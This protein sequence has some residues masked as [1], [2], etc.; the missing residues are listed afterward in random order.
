MPVEDPVSLITTDTLIEPSDSLSSAVS[1]FD[2]PWRAR[3]VIA[4]LAASLLANT[5]QWFVIGVA[6]A[7]NAVLQSKPP[8]D[9]QRFLV[10]PFTE[11]IYLTQAGFTIALLWAWIYGPRRVSWQ[12]FLPKPP[13]RE[14]APYGMVSESFVEDVQQAG[15]WLLG[16]IGLVALVVG[17]IIAGLWVVSGPMLQQDPTAAVT[18]YLQGQQQDSALWLQSKASWLRILVLVVV[19][20]VVEEVVFRGTLYA[21]LRKRR[22]LWPALLI[23][24]VVFAISHGALFN[25]PKHLVIGGMLA[26][27]YER[28]RSLRIPML[29]H[30]LWN[31]VS[32]G[33]TQPWLW[34][35]L[36]FGGV[37]LAARRL[38]QSAKSDRRTG[39]K[40]Y[41]CLLPFLFLSAHAFEPAT[42]WQLVLELPL[43][44]A[45]ILYAWKKP[46]GPRPAW[47]LYGMFY[48]CW[49]GVIVWV[50]NIPAATQAPWMRAIAEGDPSVT[51][52]DWVAEL[53]AVLLFIGPGLLATWRLANWPRPRLSGTVA[54]SREPAAEDAL[55]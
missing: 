46:A 14:V 20:P 39:W 6:F 12:Q 16:L 13:P 45:L 30:A 25:F 29:L 49:A 15:G 8:P 52:M 22:G 1:A 10:S 24:S 42:L 38:A 51:L 21:A 44:A 9:A 40:I 5:L 31:A 47:L 3:E 41:A 4:I 11:Y 28:K 18:T 17:L 26:Y 2:V 55:V 32:L 27:V 53:S 19:A 7:V 23:S 43:F 54:P 48:A 50:G 34:G 35:V 33:V 36:A 37:V